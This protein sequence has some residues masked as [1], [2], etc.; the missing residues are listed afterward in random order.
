MLSN[1][2]NTWTTIFNY[3]YSPL[4]STVD[5][6]VSVTSQIGCTAMSKMSQDTVGREENVVIRVSTSNN[7]TI[8]L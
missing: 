8:V 6:G 3:Y 1:T 7:R 5:F 2:N 4:I